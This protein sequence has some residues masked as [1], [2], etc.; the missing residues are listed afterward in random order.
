[1]SVNA[2]KDMICKFEKTGFQVFR[3]WRA[4][5]ETE[6]AIVGELVIATAEASAIVVLES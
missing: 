3:Q 1:M 4:R 6:P 5:R 2:L